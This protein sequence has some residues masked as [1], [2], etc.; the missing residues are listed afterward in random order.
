[1]PLTTLE[2]VIIVFLAILTVVA[3]A[4]ICIAIYE[5][6][7]GR[8][9]EKRELREMELY[10]KQP[11]TLDLDVESNAPISINGN[12][13][14]P[15]KS[16]VTLLIDGRNEAEESELAKGFDLLPRNEKIYFKKVEEAMRA[17]EGIQIRKENGRIV[18]IQNH[19]SVATLSIVNNCGRL[20]VFRGGEAAG[21]GRFVRY[22]LNSATNVNAGV[23]SMREANVQ[24]MK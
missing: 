5:L 22:I 17:L 15:G 2:T 4:L 20:Y 19:F 9:A 3:I 23:A 14:S 13:V 8:K 18:A 7:H 1:M 24:A 21:T 10:F 12:L 6:N 16:T 11:I